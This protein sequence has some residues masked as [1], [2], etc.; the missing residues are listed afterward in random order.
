MRGIPILTVADPR[1]M[2]IVSFVEQGQPIEPTPG[3][4]VEVRRRGQPLQVAQSQVLKVSPQVEPIPPAVLGN[5]ALLR[6]GV[7]VLIEM[8]RTLVGGRR[9]GGAF[10]DEVGAGAGSLG[11]QRPPRP[12]EVVVV[13]Y[14]VPRRGEGGWSWLRPAS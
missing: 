4:R 14:F 7:R 2:Q 5:P 6:W 1:S 11:A 8:P 3:M 10:A 12:G 13:R 9:A